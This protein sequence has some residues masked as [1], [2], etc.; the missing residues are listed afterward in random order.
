MATMYYA[1]VGVF[2]VGFYPASLCHAL[3]LLEKKAFGFAQ[4]T[5]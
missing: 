3:V 5:S 4:L 1:K 2:S